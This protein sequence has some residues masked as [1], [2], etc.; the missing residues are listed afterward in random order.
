MSEE[1]FTIWQVSADDSR[2]RAAEGLPAKLAVDYT[3]WLTQ[4]QEACDGEIH[5]IIITN[6][7][8]DMVFEWIFG[9]GV[10]F[11]SS[12]MRALHR[13]TPSAPWWLTAPC[14]HVR[15]AIKVLTR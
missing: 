12:E 9:E 5:R 1:L 2:V 14:R 15:A 11:Q 4:T 8:S 3:H 10:T 13:L 7:G 6:E